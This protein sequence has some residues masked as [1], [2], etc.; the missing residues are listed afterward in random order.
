[1]RQAG[2]GDDGGLVDLCLGRGSGHVGAVE[3]R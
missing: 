3:R 1:M 2:E